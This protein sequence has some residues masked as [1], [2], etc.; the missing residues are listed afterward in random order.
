MTPMASRKPNFTALRK[1]D[2]TGSHGVPEML[3]FFAFAFAAAVISKLVTVIVKWCMTERGIRR[4]KKK[5]I[6]Q[7]ESSRINLPPPRKMSEPKEEPFRISV[8]QIP[9]YAKL[10]PT[11]K[12]S[13][14]DVACGACAGT[15]RKS[16][17]KS[18]LKPIS[19]MDETATSE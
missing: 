9:L 5:M 6:P 14:D 18:S 17:P 8:N 10:D 13:V 19:E 1:N 3:I 2:V 15:H 11:K 4:R 12:E 16:I 7:F